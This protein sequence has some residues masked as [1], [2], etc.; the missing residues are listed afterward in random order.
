MLRILAKSTLS[1]L[2]DSMFQMKPI[3]G[4]G[5]LKPLS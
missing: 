2:E 1:F 5:Y 4:T 3:S